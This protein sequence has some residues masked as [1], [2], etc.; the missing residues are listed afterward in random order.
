MSIEISLYNFIRDH[1]N[2][3]EIKTICFKLGIDDESLQWDGKEALVRE[4]VKYSFRKSIISQVTELLKQERPNAV[5]E[6]DRLE[7][8]PSIKREYHLSHDNM[9]YDNPMKKL[10]KE[11]TLQDLHESTK[12][13]SQDGIGEQL[14]SAQSWYN[15][16]IIYYDRKKYDEATKY[17]GK[18]IQINPDYV[19]AWNYKGLISYDLKRYEE[20]TKY[21]GK[22][23]QIDPGYKLPWANMGDALDDLGRTY[24]ALLYYDK[25]IEIDP[26]YARAYREKCSL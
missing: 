23:I 9:R 15:R 1:F 22:A 24:E 25:A 4:F 10:E 12:N 13:T 3:D 21:F 26:D 6:I 14:M 2:V 8:L 7:D 18:A 5:L 20:A 16:G 19:D 17:F 11:I